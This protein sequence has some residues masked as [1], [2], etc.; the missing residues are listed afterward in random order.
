MSLLMQISNER[1]ND[2]ARKA[3]EK[4]F[5]D[6]P[7]LS[8]EYDSKRRR[9]MFQD[10]LYNLRYVEISAELDDSN[11]FTDYAV[12]LYRLL[13][14]L[15]RDLSKERIRDQMV[16]HYSI[17]KEV[18][19]ENCSE[20]EAIKSNQILDHAIKATIDASSSVEI[21]NDSYDGKYSDVRDEYLSLMMDSNTKSALNRIDSA[22]K[23]GIPIE[24]IYV[25][26]LQESMVEVGNLWHKGVIT[27]DKEHYCTT[28]TQMAMSQFYPI[29]FSQPQNGYKLVACCVGS[30]LHEMGI[31]MVSDL[32][33]LNGW[34]AI[35]SVQLCHWTPS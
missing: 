35:T 2:L 19:T 34:T 24:D 11:I 15:M 3:F 5:K 13:V 22:L 26:I 31:R 9:L 6:D 23:A 8:K 18:F 1:L 12:W 25:D 21:D 27:V 32:F 30:E 17:L 20:D 4:Q 14:N 7:S 28:T 16:M 10:T 33:E 29:I